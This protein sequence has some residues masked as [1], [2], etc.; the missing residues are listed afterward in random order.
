MSAPH[1][2]DVDPSA[3]EE[4][5]AR[6]AVAE[7]AVF[8]SVARGEARPDSD[9]DILVQWKPGAPIG[10]LAMARMADELG[11]LLGRRVDLVP[12]DGLRPRIRE[13]VLA[14]AAT[15]YVAA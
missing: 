15:L 6:W 7:L 3:L 13:A 8:G 5:C 14:A 11:A 2:L 9:V 1:L 12:R 4:F 10:F